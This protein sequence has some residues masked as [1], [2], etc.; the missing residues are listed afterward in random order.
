MSERDL[1]FMPTSSASPDFFGG[2]RPGDNRYANSVVAVRG[3]TGEVVWHFQTVHHDIWDYDLAAQ[4]N[5]VMLQT[6]GAAAP[7]PAVIQATKTGLVFALHRETG[8]PLIPVEERAVPTGAVEGEWL[9]PTQPFPVRPPPLVP[10]VIKPEDAWGF[11]FWDRGECRKRIEAARLERV[12]YAA[13]HE[14]HGALSV[15]RRRRELGRGRMGSRTAVAGREHEPG[16]ARRHAHSRR[17]RRRRGATGA[18]R[19]GVPRKRHAF[20]MMREVL[21]VA[22]RC[23]V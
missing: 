9:S 21:L 15:H 23:A 8:E 18:T 4:P 13:E 12:C 10:Q 3:S 5:L 6:D 19:T 16:D 2:E 14:G 11:T 20:G 22:A 17:A 7:V 1:V